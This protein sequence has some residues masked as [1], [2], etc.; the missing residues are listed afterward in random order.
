MSYTP[1]LNKPCKRLCKECTLV[2]LCGHLK[3]HEFPKEYYKY[4]VNYNNLFS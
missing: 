3:P 1:E 2:N 4:R